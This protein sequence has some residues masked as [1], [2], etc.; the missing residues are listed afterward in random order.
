MICNLHTHTKRCRHAKGEDREYVLRAVEGGLKILGFSDHAPFR[1]PDGHESFYR[2]PMAEAEEYISSIKALKEEFKG[3][4]DI[5][6][7]FEMEYYPLY[8]RDMLKLACSLGAEYLILGQHFISN[9]EISSRA[10]QLGEDALK[11]YVDTV[12]EGMKSGAFTYVAHPDMFKYTENDQIYKREMRRLC[13]AAK[14]L[15]IPF[16]LNFLGIRG[17]RDYPKL[18][19]WEIAGEVGVEVVFGYD[20]HLPE[21]AF[22]DVSI[23]TAMEIVEKNNLKVIEIPIIK[24]PEKAL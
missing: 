7:G 4:I 1:F 18:L 9:E 22:D 3:K 19:F 23:K 2:V 16:E 21:D 8:F 6:I 17:K 10:E 24:N 20:A 11:V 14:E 12:I 13:I 5:K 15:G